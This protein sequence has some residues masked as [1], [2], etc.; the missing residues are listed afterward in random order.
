MKALTIIQPWAWA[1]IH[2][3]KKA[4]ENRTWRTDYRGGLYVHA[5]KKFARLD[6]FPDGSPVPARG[7]LVFGAILGTVQLVDC[8]PAAD[9]PGD[10]WAA[11]PWCLVLADP[12]PLARPWPCGGALGLWTP[13]TT[14]A[15]D[16]CGRTQTVEFLAADHLCVRCGRFFPIVWE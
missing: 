6:R 9:R 10:P 2:G 3:Q 8:V 12:R 14:A 16:H 7:E 13:R 5:G 4:V 15:C 11:G 1:I